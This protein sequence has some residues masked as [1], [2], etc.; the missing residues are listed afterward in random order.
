ME[1]CIKGGKMRITVLGGCG[2]IG[3]HLV[4]RLCH[5]GH[6]VH[7][8]DDRSYGIAYDVRRSGATI[9]GKGLRK[10]TRDEGGDYVFNLIGQ[11][12]AADFNRNPRGCSGV[13]VNAVDAVTKFAK[14]NRAGFLLVS[15]VGRCGQNYQPYG[16]YI[17]SKRLGEECAK[18]SIEIL[19]VLGHILRLY[20]VYGPR[21]NAGRLISDM[22]SAATTGRDIVIYGDGSETVAPVH[23]SDVVD[24]MI[25]CMNMRESIANPLVIG[26]DTLL[27]VLDLAKL[28]K[29]LTKSKSKIVFIEM[30]SDKPIGTPD[31]TAAEKILG[32]K[33]K[34]G[35]EDGLR[36]LL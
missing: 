36:E 24:A 18:H 14:Q 11:G 2:F 19:G 21:M 16:F 1:E 5:D 28:V 35:L 13:N 7:V 15:D 25:A 26:G 34:I 31:L 9:F 3:S 4:D 20:P 33:P 8:V 29:K 12:A 17:A 23:V 10:W 6:R 22:V 30:E 27:S 32:W